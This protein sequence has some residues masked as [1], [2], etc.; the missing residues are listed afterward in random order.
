MMVECVGCFAM[1]GEI[2]ELRS[3]HVLRA[4]VEGGKAGGK[5]RIDGAEKGGGYCEGCGGGRREV[6]S[7][8]LD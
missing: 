5:V 7:W 1:E 3:E 2:I 6:R 8:R 4:K